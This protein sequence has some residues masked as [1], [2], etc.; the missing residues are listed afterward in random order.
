MNI[1]SDWKHCC[2]VKANINEQT[3]NG[4]GNTNTI[5]VTN[6]PTVNIIL[7]ISIKATLNF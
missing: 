7:K 4:V 5:I 2:C 3:G 6:Q 1:C